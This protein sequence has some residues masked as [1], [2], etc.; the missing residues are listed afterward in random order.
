[1]GLGKT[2]QAIAFLNHL[3]TFENSRGPFLV[4][5]PLTTLEHWR[6]TIEDWTDLYG[7]IT[8]VKSYNSYYTTIEMEQKGEILFVRMS[9]S[10]QRLRKKAIIKM[11]RKFISSKSL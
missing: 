1:M 10:L 4:I 6:R 7:V 8:K 9:G 3:Y 11:N 2:V 5:A